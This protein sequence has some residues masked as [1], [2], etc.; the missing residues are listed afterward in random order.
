MLN[1]LYTG[2]VVRLEPEII[3]LVVAGLDDIAVC[4]LAVGVVLVGGKSGP[5][6]L[7]HGK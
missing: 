1:N 5:T 6:T 3:G 2:P 4:I 7:P